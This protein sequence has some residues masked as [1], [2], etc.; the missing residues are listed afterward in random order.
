[1]WDL[2]EPVPPERPASVPPI[3][4]DRQPGAPAPTRDQVFWQ[5]IERAAAHQRDGKRY[6]A[7]D[8]VEEALRIRPEDPDALAYRAAL[9]RRRSIPGP[10]PGKWP[11]VMARR[12]YSTM[13]NPNFF[14]GVLVILVPM[15]IAG[16][17]AWRRR[18]AVAALVGLAL[19]MVLAIVLTWNRGGMLG[20]VA[21][22]VA[23]YALAFPRLK[24]RFRYFT[25]VSVIAGG[26]LVLL[27]AGGALFVAKRRPDAFSGGTIETRLIMWRGTVKAIADRPI[28]GHGVG[29]FQLIF[30]TYRPTDYREYR[31][32]SFNTSH[33]HCEALEL[34]TDF[35][36]IGLA[37]CLAA[38]GVFC[39]EMRRHLAR[40]PPMKAMGQPASDEGV[41][42]AWL[43]LGAAAGCLGALVGSLVGVH[44]RWAAGAWTFWTAAGVA[45][46]AVATCRRRTGPLIRRAG[47]GRWAARLL[48][49]PAALFLL[50]YTGMYALDRSRARTL[51]QDADVYITEAGKRIGGGKPEEATAILALALHALGGDRDV[52]PGLLAAGLTR[53]FEL[54]PEDV[55]AVERKIRAAAKGSYALDPYQ[56]ETLYRLGHVHH[57][58]GRM[59]ETPAG[60][61]AAAGHGV[62][63]FDV[64]AQARSI[65]YFQRLRMLAPNYARVHKQI[66]LV[67]DW[68]GRTDEAIAA[69]ERD[70]VFNPTYDNVETLL[71]LGDAYL[72]VGRS[73]R[74]LACYERLTARVQEERRIRARLAS[75]E[76]LKRKGS[77]LSRRQQQE[78]AKLEK[79]L[80]ILM[81][82]VRPITIAAGRR[83]ALARLS[84]TQTGCLARWLTTAL[85][86]A[87]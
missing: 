77:P 78:K 21:A 24:A 9:L 75:L 43:G 46:A 33:A 68:I 63:L 39:W 61:R 16:A 51:E 25:E 26:L 6:G 17:L 49:Y 27:V 83:A 79:R 35:G 60:R 18:A 1:V 87:Q 29:T 23:F 30:P 48:I 40:P 37:A 57:M 84:P 14:A 32:V 7:F 44:L 34:L 85:F 67:Y 41:E 66:G 38:L 42:V 50:V 76:D 11:F 64:E 20:A 74:A 8:A 28:F 5:L 82:A 45:L 36:A 10:N 13:V 3:P 80:G 71:G 2:Q 81:A 12:I 19:A 55:R 31:L 22:V 54:A 65:A 15:A 4:R 86:A 72:S 53:T 62:R 47:G 70:L 52:E 58:L 59:T 73:D 56:L 69:F